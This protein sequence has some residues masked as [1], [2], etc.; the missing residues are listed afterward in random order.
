M[1][2]Q[3]TPAPWSVHWNTAQGG[4]GHWIVDS[5]DLGELSRVAMVSFHDDASDKETRSNACLI[6]AAPELLSSLIACRDQ[7]AAW[8]DSGSADDA[9][10]Y[11]VKQADAAIRAALGLPKEVA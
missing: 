10:F 4:D 7:L 9:D 8:V 3:H 6:A 5:Q 2:A 1:K 11:A